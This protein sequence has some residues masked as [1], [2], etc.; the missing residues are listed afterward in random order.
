MPRD[1]A[2][3]SLVARF[4]AWLTCTTLASTASI[5][6]RERTH[7]DFLDEFRRVRRVALDF[8]ICARKTRLD[9][10]NLFAPDDERRS[11]LL[12]HR[13]VERH[14]KCGQFRLCLGRFG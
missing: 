6:R 8:F 11:N 4:T 5:A 7:T 1:H 3:R 2:S 12:G 10:A 14:A 13:R 9:R